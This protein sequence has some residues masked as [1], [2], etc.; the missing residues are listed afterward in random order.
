MAILFTLCYQ[1]I[2]LIITAIFF[3]YLMV[4]IQTGEF[5]SLI[6]L[7]DLKEKENTLYIYK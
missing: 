7:R 1:I 2:P 4:P 5:S 3:T 6:Q